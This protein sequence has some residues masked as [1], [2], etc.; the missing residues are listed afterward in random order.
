SAPW[1]LRREATEGAWLLGVPFLVQG[2]EG[3]AAEVAHVLGGAV[4]TSGEGQRLLGA[5]WRV[6]VGEAAGTGVVGG[7]G[8]RDGHRFADL[9][10][11][12][13]CA[14][15]VVKR[16]GRIVLL[17]GGEPELGEAA[18][19]LRRT[20]DPGAALDLVRKQHS[21]EGVAAFQW[22]SAAQQATIYLLSGLP[23]DTAE[24]LF[25]VPLDQAG[26]VQR[27]LRDGSCLWRADAQK[28]RGEVRKP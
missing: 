16:G 5:R 8:A 18:D 19:L 3:G 10:R 23:G 6:G 28:R 22:A 7:G 21:A 1:P 14:A 24:E 9:A 17:S 4:E 27:L 15:R 20:E 11:A 13:A 26:Q 2:I 25:T 12:L